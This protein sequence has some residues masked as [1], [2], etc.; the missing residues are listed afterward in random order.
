MQVH[1]TTGNRPT[2]HAT[3][4]SP[5]DDRLSSSN[6]FQDSNLYD[7]FF[8]EFG[9]LLVRYRITRQPIIIRNLD[10]RAAASHRLEPI[11]YRLCCPSGT[12]PPGCEQSPRRPR[13]VRWR[14]GFASRSTSPRS[15]GGHTFDGEFHFKRGLLKRRFGFWFGFGL[16]FNFGRGR[17]WRRGQM[18]KG[19]QRLRGQMKRRTDFVCAERPAQAQAIWRNS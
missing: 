15:D 12:C 3:K 18:N 10:G 2:H 1:S 8:N 14:Q 11:G 9:K 7:G 4:Y 6:S 16:G 17:R 19:I 5:R 13:F